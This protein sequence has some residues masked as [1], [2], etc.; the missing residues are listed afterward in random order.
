MCAGQHQRIP[1]C[2]RCGA[3]VFVVV[4]CVSVKASG[5]GEGPR[6]E[7]TPTACVRVFQNR[8][9]HLVILH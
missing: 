9:Q 8:G 3:R 5:G 1:V 6:G 2:E 7:H 4:K